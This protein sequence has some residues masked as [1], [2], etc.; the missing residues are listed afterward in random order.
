MSEQIKIKPVLILP[1][2]DMSKRDINQL[3]R[4]GICV[5]EAKT[6]EQVRF[7]EPP[8]HGYSV[9]ERGAIALFRYVMSASAN[10]GNWSRME[11]RAKYAEL[12]IAGTSLDPATPVKRAQP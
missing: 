3:R 12:L 11:L 8:P 6:P 4:N 2:G 10:L 5:V 9:Q 7:C 1:T